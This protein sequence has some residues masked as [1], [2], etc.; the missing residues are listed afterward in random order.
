ME[1]VGSAGVENEWR[2]ET[3]A[4]MAVLTQ[5]LHFLSFTV[6]PQE[7]PKLKTLCALYSPEHPHSILLIV[8]S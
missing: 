3:W 6:S 5:A 2:S 4:L 1:A 7:S 8:V